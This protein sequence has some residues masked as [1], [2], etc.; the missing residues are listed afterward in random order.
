[1]Q[2][3][4]AF[5]SG[6]W[7]LKMLRIFISLWLQNRICASHIC[8]SLRRVPD[9]VAKCSDKIKYSHCSCLIFFLAF[10]SLDPYLKPD[11]LFQSGMPAMSPD[12]L[13]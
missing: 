4:G 2:V 1:M 3:C 5:C 10:T 12:P 13:R 6:Y 11:V 9:S 7:A 8:H